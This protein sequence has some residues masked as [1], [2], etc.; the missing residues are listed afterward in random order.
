MAQETW[1]AVIA[2][3]SRFEGKAALSTWI[4]AILLN[5]AKTFAKREGRYTSLAQE[6]DHGDEELGSRHRASMPPAIGLNRQP[7]SMA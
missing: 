4:I 2:N 3:I 5:K 1:L 6:E 7:L